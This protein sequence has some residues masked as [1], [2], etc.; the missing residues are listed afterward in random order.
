MV[1][2]LNGVRQGGVLSPI[3][4]TVY[5]DD[6]LTE[7][8]NKGVG[9][10]WNNHFVG[11]LCY[12]DDIALLA[13]SSAALRLMLDT[14]SS[15]ASSRSLLF[16]ASKIQLSLVRFS[17]TC[18]LHC[19]PSFF[20]N[21]LELNLGHS[22]KHLGHLLSFNLSD[23]DD[24]VRVKNDLVRKA[25]CM[26]HSFSHCNPLVKTKLFDSFCLSLY[27]SSLVFFLS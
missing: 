24:I 5:I 25:N 16:N 21:G 23:T 6:L 20:F 7:L 14:Y 15:F 3:L 19:S 18:S 2:F 9:C 13:P 12:A 4:F 10:Y 11:T 26:L 27:G 8:E 22:A 1:N 17:R